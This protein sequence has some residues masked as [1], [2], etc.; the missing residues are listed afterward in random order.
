[1]AG[2]ETRAGE[3]EK[4]ARGA[5]GS[6][7]PDGGIDAHGGKENAGLVFNNGGQEHNKLEGNISRNVQQVEASGV[8]YEADSCR[9]G[10]A[11]DDNHTSGALATKREGRSGNG[12]G[13]PLEEVLA[14]VHTARASLDTFDA[15]YAE[16]LCEVDP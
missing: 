2:V 5:K 3:R 14:R 6:S 16:L 7:K 10:G 11:A 4:K 1:V 12:T 13:R 8:Q 9:R 15:L